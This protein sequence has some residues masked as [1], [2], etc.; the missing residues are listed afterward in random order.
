MSSA[1]KTLVTFKSL[2]TACSNNLATYMFHYTVIPL[3]HGKDYD[4]LVLYK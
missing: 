3:Y 1:V 4:N 2:Y